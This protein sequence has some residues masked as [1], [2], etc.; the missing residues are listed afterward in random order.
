MQE[1]LKLVQSDLA[2]EPHVEHHMSLENKPFL[3]SSV[4]IDQLEWKWIQYFLGWA[5]LLTVFCFSW[6][7]SSDKQLLGRVS[8][9]REW[10]TTLRHSGQL[11][12]PPLWMPCKCTMSKY[13]YKKYNPIILES[14]ALMLPS[15]KKGT[16]C[17][18][19]VRTLV[20]KCL[21]YI[22][23]KRRHTSQNLHFRQL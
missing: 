4:I 14:A 6:R 3:L 22:G 23:N 9:S 17:V 20:V 15:D 1:W 7:M 16:V 11:M 13:D 2:N 18:S 8:T 12:K 10:D 19:M 21:H 5:V